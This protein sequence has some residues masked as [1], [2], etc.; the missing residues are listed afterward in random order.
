MSADN[1]NPVGTEFT[2]RDSLLRFLLAVV[3]ATAGLITA[4][5]ATIYGLKEQLTTKADQQAVATLESRLIRIEAI[6][7]ERV[8][9]KAELRQLGDLLSGRLQDIDTRLKLIPE[10][11]R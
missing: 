9:T 8:A 4:Y 3:I 5:H 6:L 11:G 2:R 1:G 7:E 10:E